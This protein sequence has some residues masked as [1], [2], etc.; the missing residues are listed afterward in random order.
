MA[1]TTYV[2]GVTVLTADTMNDVNRVVYTIL[3]DPADVAA[4]KTALGLG[5]A[6]SVTFGSVNNTP[7]GSTTPSSGVFSS[8]RESNSSPPASAAA[9]GVAGQI[10]WDSSFIY[11]CVATNTW[12]RVAIATW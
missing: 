2:D 3:A 5:T 6:N 1:D 7:I 8:L 11:V 9:A 12:K 4:A 10:E